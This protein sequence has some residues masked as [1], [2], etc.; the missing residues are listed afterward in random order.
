ME[1]R[2]RKGGTFAKYVTV[3]PIIITCNNLLSGYSNLLLLAVSI[4]AVV[5]QKE[6]SS[7][8]GLE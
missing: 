4:I 8:E 6:F 1:K 5:K 7:V 3:K 2:L